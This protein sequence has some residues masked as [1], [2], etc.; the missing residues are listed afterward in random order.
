MESLLNLA[1]ARKASKA[2]VGEKNRRRRPAM[3]HLWPW[4][5]ASKQR[6]NAFEYAA[7]NNASTQTEEKIDRAKAR[8][9][10]ALKA[11]KNHPKV[12]NSSTTAKQIVK[13]VERSARPRTQG[14]EE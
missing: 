6:S 7:L 14:Q 5:N 1:A 9:K 4:Q 2:K 11:L 8:K 13:Y 10:D 12:Q 3:M